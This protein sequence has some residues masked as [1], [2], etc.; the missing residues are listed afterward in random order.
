[1]AAT[2]L[3][4]VLY[5][6]PTQAQEPPPARQ[7]FVSRQGSGS[8][9]CTI[10][11]P[12]RTFNQANSTVA[13]GGEI[14]ALDPAG[15]SSISISKAVSVQGHGF[16]SI[17]PA[18]PSAGGIVIQAG[19]SEKVNL[20]GLI[21]DGA[22][23]GA[24]GIAFVSG[25]SLVIANSVVRNWTSSGIA[26]GPTNDASISISNTLVADNGGHGIYI[27]PPHPNVFVTATFTRVEVD[28][29]AQ[30]GIGI[31]ANFGG[32]IWAT[33]VDSVATNNGGNFYA[34]G[35]LDCDD[36]C[37]K[38]KV[39][40]SA[41]TQGLRFNNG[42]QAENNAQ[43]AVGQSS[44]V[45]FGTAGAWTALNSGQVLSFGDNYAEDPAP[46]GTIPKE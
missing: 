24:T 4:P 40:R 17:A 22:A 14:D 16:A 15:Y 8:N 32:L 25:G 44:M 19:P 18:A 7:V 9:P 45:Y 35:N 46:N 5:G 43:I 23:F 6:V 30:K 11:A 1:M 2:M 37:A 21:I 34:L 38:M 26:I 13:A 3:V 42:I 10:A 27:Q 29:N 20:N 41:S 33:V 28:N 12:C 31:F 39:I 36:G